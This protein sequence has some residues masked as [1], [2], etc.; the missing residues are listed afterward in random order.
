[1]LHEDCVNTT[2]GAFKSATV[3]LRILFFP[4]YVL[5]WFV[6]E[7]SD[8]GRWYRRQRR[9]MVE[10]RPPLTD[11]EFLQAV[12]AAP[13]DAR[14]WL[15]ARRAV[16]E[17]AG[18]PSEAVYPQDRLADLWRMQ[19]VGPDLLDFHFR[20]EIAL[21]KKLAPESVT[22]LFGPLRYGQPG[23]FHE[24]AA[25]VVRRIR[26]AQKITVQR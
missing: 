23:E 14:L 24:F 13:A 9:S 7:I 22:K 11:D 4:L 18:V 21:D 3:A 16:A 8:E 2:T 20:M 6:E 19:W 26:E 15:A 5:V 10:E 1:M 12:S 25:A 17:Q